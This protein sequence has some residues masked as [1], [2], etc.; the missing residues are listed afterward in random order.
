MSVFS[1]TQEKIVSLF[2]QKEQRNCRETKK[3]VLP[4]LLAMLWCWYWLI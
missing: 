2:W 1:F 3:S 4:V